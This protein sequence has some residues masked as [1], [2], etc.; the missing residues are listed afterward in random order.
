[1]NCHCTSTDRTIHLIQK[2]ETKT[3]KQVEDIPSKHDL[4]HQFTTKKK[5]KKNSMAVQLVVSTLCNYRLIS[6]KQVTRL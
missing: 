6:L 2:I 5:K 1:M 4:M 3:N